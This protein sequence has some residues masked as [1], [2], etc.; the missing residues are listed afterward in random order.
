MAGIHIEIDDEEL[1]NYLQTL[2][3]KAR[4][5]SVPLTAIGEHLLRSHH[6]RWEQQKSPE[7][8]PWLPLTPA[9]LQSKRKRESRGTNLA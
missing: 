8:T 7:G 2:Q 6:E 1:H 4:D 3:E 5:L 9:Y